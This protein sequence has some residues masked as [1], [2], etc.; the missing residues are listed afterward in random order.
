MMQEDYKEWKG[1]RRSHGGVWDMPNPPK[2]DIKLRFQVSG[3][4]GY[5][6]WVMVDNALPSY[7]KAGAFYD[8]DIHLY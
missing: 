2:G 5:G 6:K 7:W 8:T 3:S 1:M 4:M